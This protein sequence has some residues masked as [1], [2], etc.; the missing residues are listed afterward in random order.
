[1]GTRLQRHL[2]RRLGLTDFAALRAQGLARWNSDCYRRSDRTSLH[3]A[4]KRTA[5]CPMTGDAEYKLK[6]VL[7]RRSSVSPLDYIPYARFPVLVHSCH[8]STLKTALPMPA[9]RAMLAERFR[10]LPARFTSLSATPPSASYRDC[11]LSC[12]QSFRQLQ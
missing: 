8:C 3:G 6:P 7:A 5:P 1:M 10:I 12:I 11:L 4:A 9:R 2:P